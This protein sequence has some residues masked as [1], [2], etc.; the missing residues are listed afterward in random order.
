MSMIDPGLW[1][2]IESPLPTGDEL[3][4][5]PAVPEVTSRLLAAIDSRGHRHLLVSLMAGEKDFRDASSRGVKITTQELTLRAGEAGR[6]I[7][8]ACED[9]S[10]HPMLD[11]IG[12][13]LAGRLAGG[14]SSAENVARVLAK[15]RR[16]WGRL[17]QQLLSHEAQIGLFAELWFLAYWL[18][19]AVGIS[20]AVRMW[21]GPHGTRHDFERKGLS[22]E[23]KGTAS[24][25]GRLHQINGVDQLEAPE[26]GRLL[27]FSLRMRDEAGA[28]NTLPLLCGV[29]RRLISED[30]D[31]EGLFDTT[32]F[33][34]GYLEMHEE[35]Y[36]KTHWRV[37]D[38]LLFDTAAGFP[39]ITAGSF[40]AGMPAGVEDLTYT[41][42]LGTFDDLIVARRAA[43]ATVFLRDTA[44]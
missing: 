15:W 43:E 20:D 16:F 11:L 1:R 17:P 13:D 14:G 28:A 3:I 38:E 21:R 6:Y 2:Q 44:D 7:D 31:A 29:C 22:I 8:I 23:C 42:N 19:P 34:A 18:I 33:A 4:G 12:G 39:R 5:R 9:V 37:L 40:A 24:T 26:G 27:F 35:E 25:R 30:G 32:M 36:S 10:G 41:I